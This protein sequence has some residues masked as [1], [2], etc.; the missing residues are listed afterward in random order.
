MLDRRMND[1]GKN[2]RHVFKALTV[3]DYCLHSG[4]ENVVLW[5][6]DNIYVIKT[7]R[8]FQYVDDEGRDHG[9]N[10]RTKAKE[11]TALLMDEER[12]RSERTNRDKM[13]DRMGSQSAF[14]ALNN[15]QSRRGSTM[16]P[17]GR[18]RNGTATFSNDDDDMRKAIE[19]SKLQE[20]EDMARRARGSN[21][22]D[23][24]DEELQRALQLSR[25]E[26]EKRQR[27]LEKSNAN[28]LFDDSYV[29]QPQVQQFTGYPYPQQQPMY[30]GYVQPTMTGYQFQQ[31]YPAPGSHNP[32]QQQQQ[33]PQFTGYQSPG[34]NNPF[35]NDQPAPQAP[36]SSSP[37]NQQ[38]AN[39][40]T[41]KLNEILASG[42]G[43]DTF[44]NSGELRVPAHHAKTTATF[45]NSS[46]SGY[47]PA[48]ANPFQATEQEEISPRPVR[49]FSM[50]QPATYQTAM[51]TG[52]VGFG[53]YTAVQ[54]SYT[55][56]MGPQITASQNP[57]QQQYQVNPV[58]S[59]QSYHPFPTQQSTQQNTASG[60]QGSLID[61]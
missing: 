59:H 17:A 19:A 52:A 57:Q 48:G 45:A 31:Q 29:I 35:Q 47:R 39:P 27:E 12:L 14:S 43:V 8:E 41:A 55:G 25:E 30:T 38:D 34:S 5:A 33:Q 46:G 15:A 32:F 16:S 6:K 3:L 53:G 54:P 44:G 50:Q 10:V 13:R 1:K 58:M 37:Q 11:I 28:A 21:N 49:S 22:R 26:E 42:S 2:W 60:Q 9:L 36:I 61:F 20:Q 23:D 4:S 56:Y 51:P 7:L 40:Y 18:R 24:D